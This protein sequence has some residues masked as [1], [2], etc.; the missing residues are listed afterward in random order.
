MKT[1]VAR[2]THCLA[3]VNATH[4]LPD[5]PAPDLVPIDQHNPKILLERQAARLLSSCLSAIGAQGNIIP[6]SGWRSREEQQN[7]WDETLQEKGISFTRQYVAKPGCSEHETGL[8]IDLGLALPEIDFIRPAFPDSGICRV[9]RQKAA[10]YGF[11]LRYPAGKEHITGI[12]H[13]PWHFRYVG[14]PH[15]EIISSLHLTLEEYLCMLRQYT[16]ARPLPFQSDAYRFHI[17]YLPAPPD[18][19][20]LPKEDTCYQLSTDNCGGWILTSWKRRGC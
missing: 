1:L 8:A 17:A 19:S 12:A 10:K 20:L 6:V 9:F 16:I 18:P 5:D 13:E 2:Q 11:I 14:A 7:I 15:G 4:P 3:L